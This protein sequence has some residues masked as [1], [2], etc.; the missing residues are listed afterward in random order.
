MRG[1][2][3]V[4]DAT[5]FLL[6]LGVAVATIV[7][8][9][10]VTEDDATDH[11]DAIAEHLATGTE[12][13]DYSLAPAARALDGDPPRAIRD[14]PP[15]SRSAHGTL[16]SLLGDAAVA[17]VTVEERPISRD[18]GAFERA[19]VNATEQRVL[20]RNYSVGVRAVWTPYP[21]SPVE[22][23]VHAGGRPPA[24]ADV[25]AATVS[26]D[27][28]IPASR[29]AAVTAAREAGFEGVADAVSNAIVEGLFPP[30]RT[31]LALRGDYPVDALV[32]NRY[33]QASAAVGGALERPSPQA[34][35]AAENEELASDLGDLLERD[36][37]GQ[38]STPL[39]AARNV[40][41]GTVTITVR[42]WSR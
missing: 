39:A 38:Y 6:V 9:P 16:A 23:R 31:S 37:R 17:T 35:V 30:N 33:A 7:A 12:R 22:G 21:G 25:N 19:V 24:T 15:F 18:G 41:T 40:S 14:G 10:M 20:R 26:V 5:L 3:T 27:A 13:V 8:V 11:A 29:D 4:V 42:T 34:D 32:A 36:L 28:P 1:V 2:S